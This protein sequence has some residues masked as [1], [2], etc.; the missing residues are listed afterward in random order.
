MS[1]LKFFSVIPQHLFTLSTIIVGLFGIGLLIAFHEFGHFIFAKIF[2]VKTPSFSIGFGP[3]IISK[4]IGETKFSLSLFPLGG[5]VELAGHQEMG[6]GEQKEATREDER[7]FAKKNYWQKLLIMSGGIIFNI[8]FAYIVVSLLFFVGLPKSKYLAP[9]NRTSTISYI[10]KES[11][12]A[13]AGLEKGDT[14]VQI[15]G[16]FIEPHN[17]IPLLK[18]I[19]GHPDQTLNFLIQ[20]A[21]SEQQVM[22]PVAIGSMERNGEHM[23]FIGTDF[24]TVAVA[25]VSLTKAIA[26]GIRTTN[27]WIKST[28]KSFIHMFKSRNYGGVGGPLLIISESAKEGGQGWK[29][30]FVFLAIISINLAILNLIPLPILDGGQIL[31]QTIEAVL[32]REIPHRVR[33]YIQIG[34]WALIMSLILYASYKDIL[35]FFKF[36]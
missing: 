8:A 5:Y 36:K 7:S 19:A 23:G 12:A 22:I 11:P 6:Q 4:K 25:P 29:N 15:D 20:K 21:G 27:F 1:F 18:T 14:I 31:F 24:E 17:I 33:E 13:K 32:G 28:V 10:D 9:F 2:N 26:K 34:S 16:S 35:R 30:L 3:Q